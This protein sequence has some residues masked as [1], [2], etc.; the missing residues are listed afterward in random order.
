MKPFSLIILSFATLI[1]CF[2]NLYGQSRRKLV[3]S[4]EFNY[5]GL[6]DS[7]KWGYDIGGAGWGN[8]E[9]QFYTF[10]QTKNARV[11]NGHLI[12]EARK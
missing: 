4:D 11:E 10:Q 8:D 6:P 12:I 5:N 2:S 3:W 9:L 7:T 1:A